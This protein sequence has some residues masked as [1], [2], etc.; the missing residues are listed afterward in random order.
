MIVIIAL[1]SL[2][3]WYVTYT[4]TELDGPGG[5]F[6]KLRS[7]GDDDSN[8]LRCFYCTSFWVS[9]IFCYFNSLSLL[10]VFAFAG[11]AC[12]V[13]DIHERLA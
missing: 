12:L 5:V 4:L 7:L 8:P 2:A 6:N 13:H 3:I 11:F 1:F 9:A 10:F